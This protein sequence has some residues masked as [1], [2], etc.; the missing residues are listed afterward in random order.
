MTPIKIQ[1]TR[2]EHILAKQIRHKVRSII[3][4]KSLLNTKQLGDREHERLEREIEAYERHIDELV[5]KLYRV[6]K[7]HD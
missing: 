5:C 2:K 4:N 3:N 1:A 6:D 7:I